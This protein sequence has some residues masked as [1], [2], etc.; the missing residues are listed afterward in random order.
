VAGAIEDIRVSVPRKLSANGVNRVIATVNGK[1]L[2][3]ESEGTELDAAPEAFA[4]ALLPDAVDAGVRLVSEAPLDPIWIRN[5]ARVLRVWNGWW[6]TPAQ[7][8]AVLV[9]ATD[10]RNH[11]PAPRADVGLCFTLGVD[12]FYTLLRS[13]WNVSR[14]IIAHGYDVKLGDE[15]RMAAIRESLEQVARVTGASPAIVRTNLREHPAVGWENWPRTHG[16][17]LAALGH[18]CRDTIGELLISATKP[19]YADAPWGSHWETDPG[20]SSARVRVS[21]VGAERRRNDKLAAMLDEPLV[22]QHLR[23]CWENRAPAGNCG[24]CEKCLRTMLVL[25]S[26]GR[27]DDFPVF[28]DRSSLGAC[29]DALPAAIPDVVPVYA[30]ALAKIRDRRLRSAVERLIERS[31][32]SPGPPRVRRKVGRM[33]RSRR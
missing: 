3:F 33:R 19:Y 21:H 8:E 24:E 26:H 23:V 2:F 17:P 25:E 7:A 30:T 12:S 22:Q 28:P 11:A 29:I 20:W 13:T 6:G 15:T 31:L 16:G 9:A 14:L 4:S 5:A 1:E 32:P 10:G 18:V 27:L